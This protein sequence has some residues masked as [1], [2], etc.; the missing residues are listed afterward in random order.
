M[1]CCKSKKD[2]NKPDP[3]VPVPPNIVGYYSWGWNGGSYGQTGANIGIAFT[4]YA[5]VA[6]VTSY[7]LVYPELLHPGRTGG[8]ITIGGNGDKHG[9][10]TVEVI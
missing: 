5:T 8:W 9:N 4:G 3:P 7:P 1:G 6:A 10:F 2:D